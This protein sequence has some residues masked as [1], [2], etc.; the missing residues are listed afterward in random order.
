MFGLRD[1]GME[2]RI[3]CFN[4]DVQVQWFGRHV[5]KSFVPACMNWN[6]CESAHQ[7]HA[8]FIDFG[9]ISG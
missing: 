8:D 9:Q 4:C 1:L 5:K 7:S 6:D 3:W 2:V